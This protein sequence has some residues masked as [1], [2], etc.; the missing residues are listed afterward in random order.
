MAT[1]AIG[2]V[3]NSQDGQRLRSGSPAGC[4]GTFQARLIL[5]A[6][7]LRMRLALTRPRMGPGDP[8]SLNRLMQA[9]VTR[10]L[11]R[12]GFLGVVERD[13]SYA[14]IAVRHDPDDP[15]LDR[16]R[17]RRLNIRIMGLGF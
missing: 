14:T 10:R 9:L 1:G 2:P 6:D 12:A 15:V 13:D 11:D 8:T 4:S 5:G 17:D 16:L 7:S 3:R